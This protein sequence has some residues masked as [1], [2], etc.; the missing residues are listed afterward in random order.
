MRNVVINARFLTQQITG[1]QRFAIELSKRIKEFYPGIEFVA[2]FNIKQ[3]QLAKD[4]NVK[5]IGFYS[6]HLWEQLDLVNYLKSKSNPLLI[7]LAN[8]APL[9]YKK[10][11]VAIHDLAWKHLPQSVSKKFYFWYLFMTKRIASSSIHFI[12]VSNFSKKD[13]S[14]NLGIPKNKIT[15]I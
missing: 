1:V 11:I 2:P 7:C 12:T 6:G 4:L 5:V 15:V 8:T 10:K 13:I 3:K 9:Y 14:K